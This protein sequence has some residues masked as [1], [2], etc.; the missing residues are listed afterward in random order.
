MNITSVLYCV[1][2]HRYTQTSVILGVIHLLL[3]APVYSVPIRNVI[4]KRITCG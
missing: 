3:Y 1:V 2:I 4:L